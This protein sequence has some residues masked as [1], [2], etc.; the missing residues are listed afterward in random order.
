MTVDLILIG[1]G[2]V[3]QRFVSLLDEQRTTLARQYGISPRI[4]GIATRRHGQAF[5]ARGLDVASVTDR[6]WDRGRHARIPATT[7]LKEPRRRAR[8]APGRRR[9]DDARRE[10]RRTGSELHPHR[11]CGERARDHGEQGT[12]RLRL[13]RAAPGGRACRS[14]VAVRGCG[15]GRRAGF[16]SRSRDDAGR[17]DPRLPR[18]RQQH[19]ELHPHRDGTGAT[20]RRCAG[21]D[22]G[23][24]ASRRPTPRWTSMGGTRRQKRRRSQTYCSERA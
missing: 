20:L 3:G 21:G 9:N 18:H 5:S 13:R 1:F 2:N 19:D 14:P 15:D 11:P 8:T 10:S 6:E 24:E 22:A 7:R 12:C 16:Q 23:R 17:E 4:V